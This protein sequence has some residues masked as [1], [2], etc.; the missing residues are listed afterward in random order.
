MSRLGFSIVRGPLDED[1][2]KPVGGALSGEGFSFFFSLDLSYDWIQ[3]VK[4]T[5][6]DDIIHTF[7]VELEFP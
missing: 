3:V 1:A 4:L 6:Y 5:V 2:G 7:F